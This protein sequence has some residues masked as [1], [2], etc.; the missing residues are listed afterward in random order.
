MSFSFLSL[1]IAGI[2][3]KIFS[4]V[5]DY[6]DNKQISHLPPRTL[7]KTITEVIW[8]L[9]VYAAGLTANT[10]FNVAHLKE[11]WQIVW[12]LCYFNRYLSSS[13]IYR[14]V[15]KLSRVSPGA[16]SPIA[17]SFRLTSTSRNI[18]GVSF[19]IL[20]DWLTILTV[21]MSACLWINF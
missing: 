10:V 11:I 7:M 13:T 6:N 20:T 12:M 9:G 17:S 5:K 2:L 1:T 18:I 14:N 4:Q 16:S 21:C 8:E 19:R 3:L 15:R